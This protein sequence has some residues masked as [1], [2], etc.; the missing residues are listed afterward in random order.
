MKYLLNFLLALICAVLLARWIYLSLKLWMLY[1][2]ELPGHIP[3]NISKFHQKPRPMHWLFV[4]DHVHPIHHPVPHGQYFQ[5]N[6]RMALLTGSPNLE[7]RTRRNHRID[8][9]AADIAHE[10][11]RTADKHK[12]SRAKEI[13]GS[14]H[15]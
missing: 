10:T 11:H 8:I 1:R 12:T 14:G 9:T 13:A 15:H 4:P 7:V 2:H 6:N 3:T 5:N